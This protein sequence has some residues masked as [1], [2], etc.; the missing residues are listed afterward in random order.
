MIIVYTRF[1]GATNTRGSRIVATTTYFGRSVKTEHNKNDA[2]SGDENHL[3]AAWK[4]MVK[5]AQARHV[6]ELVGQSDNPSGSGSAWVF[7]RKEV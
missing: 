3:S 2:L 6:Y 7:K 1:A 4:V 5:A